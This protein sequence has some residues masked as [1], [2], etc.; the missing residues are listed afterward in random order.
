ML[1]S[2]FW[3]MNKKL[4]ALLIA[5]MTLSLLGIIFVQGY[6][7][8]TSYQ[9]KEDQFTINVRNVLIATSKEINKR[10][11]DYYFD[12]FSN[13][14]DSVDK[15]DNVTVS[16][17]IYKINN[18]ENTEAYIFSDGVLEEDY[19]LTSSFLDTEIE[20][21]QYKKL[22]S[23]KSTTK[24]NS[25]VDGGISPKTRIESFNRLKDYE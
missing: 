20:S 10:E 21:F 14:I 19:K 13:Y 8:K 16:E 18:E 2:Y 9:T 11:V 6:W 5:L 12:I 3:D 25:G 17:L 7:I 24:V 23:K 22:T 15:P 4:F 1:K